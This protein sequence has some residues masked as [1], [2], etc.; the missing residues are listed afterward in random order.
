MSTG[1]KHI[2]DS[3]P[4]ISS[5]SGTFLKPVGVLIGLLK[6]WQDANTGI[7][8]KPQLPVLKRIAGKEFMDITQRTV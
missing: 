3:S 7:S 5:L 1:L 2:F 6:P 4:V 8:K